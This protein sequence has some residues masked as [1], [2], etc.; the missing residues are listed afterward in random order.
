MEYR[1]LGR[2]GLR[3]SVVGYGTAPLGDMFGNSDE[4]T[5]LQ[6][7]Y[8]ALDAGI[9]FFDSSPFY[10][11][12]LAEER[13]GKV[14][15]GRRH[16][17]IVGTKAGRYGPEEFDFSAERIR[18]GVEESLRLLGTDY[19]DILQLHDVEFV[20][21]EGP[22]GEGYGELVQLRDAGMCRFI[23]MTGYPTAMT[24]R[25]MTECDLDVTLSYAH[26][27]LLDACLADEVLPLAQ[28]R[29]VGVINAAA[30]A[31]GLLTEAGPPAHIAQVVGEEIC[32]VARRIV[33]VCRRHGANVSF[34]ANQY[35]IQRSG[36][37][38]TLIGTTKQRHLDSAVAAVEKPIDEELLA[39]VLAAA[40]SDRGRHWTSGLAQ[41][42]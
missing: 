14:L 38:T 42:N 28:E 39:D 11:R 18:R 32:A 9:N 1:E 15:R 4:E 30:V 10:G 6:S 33:E 26:C 21:L 20:D 16:E 34:L 29:E 25:V 22:I 8:R 40:G 35:S 23:G 24:R 31:L 36:C 2:T 41:N 5:A 19:V 13:L 7:A 27:T 12:G 3:L 37:A 17:I